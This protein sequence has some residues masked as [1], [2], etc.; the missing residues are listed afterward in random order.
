MSDKTPNPKK[1]LHTWLPKVILTFL[2]FGALFFVIYQVTGGM[3]SD[4]GDR[5]MWALLVAMGMLLLLPVVDRI[6]TLSLSPTGFEATMTEAQAKAIKE[7]G[8]MVED[9]KAAEAAQ[10]QILQAKSPEQV[11][12]A[13]AQAVELNVTRTVDVVREAIQNKHKC[14][15]R[16]R[17]A[18]DE[19]VQSYHVA[20]LDIKK[21]KSAATKTNDYLWAYSYE[22]ESIVSLRLDRV[23]GIE[24]SEET[25]DPAEVTTPGKKEW[26]VPREW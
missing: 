4:L 2:V 5:S 7:V 22:H 17:S 26:N 21:G 6:Q 15:V 10:E 11:K 1:P 23:I 13:V 25:F 16:Y 8:A 9:P 19:P 24:P 12:A 20:P 3:S 18:P 14:Y